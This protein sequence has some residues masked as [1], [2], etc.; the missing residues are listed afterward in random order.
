MFNLFTGRPTAT[1][2]TAR[3]EPLAP[4]PVHAPA[5]HIPA[6]APGGQ[7]PQQQP[8]P[9]PQNAPAPE[10]MTLAQLLAGAGAAPKPGTSRPDPVDFAASFIDAIGQD[11]SGDLNQSATPPRVNPDLLR[12]AFNNVDLTN[13]IDINALVAAMQTGGDDAATTLQ[14]AL[15]HQSLNTLQAM[16]PIINQLVERA[17]EQASERAVTMSQ[18][19]LTADTIVTAFQTKYPYASNPVASKM[20]AGFA[21]TVSKTMPRGTPIDTIVDGIAHMFKGMSTGLGPTTDP[22]QLNIP[23]GAQTDFRGIF[24]NPSE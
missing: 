10:T 13:G 14:A 22:Q 19:N 8:A 18:H 1:P 15:Q 5:P 11:N 2:T 17:F 3:S 9:A 6:P 12:T 4:A 24:G 20:L 21:E 23:R 16:T 7:Q